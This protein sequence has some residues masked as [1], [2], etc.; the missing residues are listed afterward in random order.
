MDNIKGLIYKKDGNIIS[1]SRASITDLSAL[2][3]P[4]FGDFDLNKYA[5]HE[6]VLPIIT[7]RGCI[8]NCTF[9]GETNQIS[10]FR[11]VPA[12]RVADEIQN[13]IEMYGV[14]IF[15]INDSLVNG[16][17]RVLEEWIDEII[18]RN[19]QVEFGAAQSRID[20]RMSDQL[21]KKMEQAGCKLIQYG[22]ESG[23]NRL[24]KIYRK[25]ITVD[26]AYDVIVR[27]KNAGISIQVNIMVGHFEETLLDYLKTIIFLIKVR[28]YISYVNLN[29]YGF[30]KQSSDFL[31]PKNVINQFSE[32][33][34]STDRLN[35]LLLRKIKKKIIKIQLKILGIKIP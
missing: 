10:K 29:I 23:S 8:A 9:C 1:N 11:Q 16:N 5:Y 4:D 3:F 27:T 19:L 18:S 21:L 6:K 32:N 31:K 12:K 35:N 7:T 33:W 15:R 30:E 22:V 28:K 34:Y 20:G 26:E 17:L 2:P 13:N 14:K 25:G 24:L